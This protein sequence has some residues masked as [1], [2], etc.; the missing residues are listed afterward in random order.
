MGL[1]PDR[2]SVK[3]TDMGRGRVRV[4]DMEL[5]LVKD[6]W[7]GQKQGIIDEKVLVWE[8]FLINACLGIRTL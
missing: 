5:V 6:M 2:G 8:L 1:G 4:S 3:V 7:W